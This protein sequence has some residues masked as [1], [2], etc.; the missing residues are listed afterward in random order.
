MINIEKHE[1]F[2]EY[3]SQYIHD[4]KIKN[5]RFA[6]IYDKFINLDKK[7]RQI[8]LAEHGLN[9]FE[10]EKLKKERLQ[11]RDEA[12]KILKAFKAE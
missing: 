1:I 8:E 7:I 11:L 3:N 2:E 6:N 12:Q 9:D 4:I 5:A 10:L